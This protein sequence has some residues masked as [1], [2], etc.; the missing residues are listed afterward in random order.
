M[1]RLIIKLVIGGWRDSGKRKREKI[2]L[3]IGSKEEINYREL[4][5]I[6]GRITSKEII[7]A[8]SSTIS[9][10]SLPNCKKEEICLTRI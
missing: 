5:G 10:T 6:F 1:L 3:L 2:H 8:F 7:L 4:Q 9:N